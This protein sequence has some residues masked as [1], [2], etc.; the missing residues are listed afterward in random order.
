MEDTDLLPTFTSDMD[1][2]MDDA[3]A[4]P[5]GSA[6]RNPIAIDSDSDG[7]NDSDVTLLGD[8]D[9]EQAIRSVPKGRRRKHRAKHQAASFRGL[10]SHTQNRRT[11]Q[12]SRTTHLHDGR[13]FRVNSR[14]QHQ[15]RLVIE[16]FHFENSQR[17]LQTYSYA[18]RTLKPGK[19][20]ELVDGTFMRIETTLELPGASNILLKGF[21]YKRALALSGLLEFKRNE[22]AMVFRR[23]K[24]DPRDILEQSIQTVG[25]AK[26]VRIRELVKTN[27]QFPALSYREIDQGSIR[28]GKQH[29]LD[30]CRLV[31]RWKYLEV[32]KNEGSLKRLTEEE[33][34]D[35]CSISQ[36]ESRYT[37][38]GPTTKG[39]DSPGRLDAEEAFHQKERAKC[40]FIDPLGFYARANITT[41]RRNQRTY[42]FGDAYCGVGGAS[43]GALGAGLHIA[44]GFDN[45]ADAITNYHANFPYTRC[46]GIAAN[47]F[48]TA[49]DDDYKVDILHLS[50]PCQPFSP[51][52]TR[53]GPND[54]TNEATFLA[55]EELIKKTRPRIVTIEET[56]GL[57]GWLDHVP[58]FSALIQIL[59]KLG[60]SVRWNVFNLQELGLPQPRRRLFLFAS[61]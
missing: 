34:D 37:F 61:W 48:V 8:E 30:H 38:R 11:S 42:T 57:T 41:H 17:T 58:W 32:S 35:G 44:F 43:R 45:N 24:D 25:L 12:V 23:A 36:E 28:M 29:I 47:D 26:V 31:C 56:F 49:L 16:S 39:G 51:A 7:S 53:P 55:T 4:L 40:S 14:A 5:S 50:P 54:E 46:E 6:L 60:F 18:G 22:V 13:L 27:Q 20:V 1:D 19:T 15:S 59:T 2:I 33:S 21:L 52:H 3:D 10:H 9:M